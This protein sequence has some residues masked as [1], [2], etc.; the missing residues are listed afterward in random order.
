MQRSHGNAV[1]PQPKHALPTVIHALRPTLKTTTSIIFA[2]I[3]PPK[4]NALGRPTF[5]V[6]EPLSV[7]STAV[8]ATTATLA[9]YFSSA[10]SCS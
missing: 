9:L 7:T 4:L 6:E 10:A 1:E 3:A 5:L 2:K 8:I